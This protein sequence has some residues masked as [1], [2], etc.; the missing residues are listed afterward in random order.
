[1]SIEVTQ[2]LNK[3]E[4]ILLEYF[5]RQII[6][7]EKIPKE[8]PNL[9][10]WSTIIKL[11]A[12]YKCQICKIRFG[13]DSHHIHSI[14]KHNNEKLIIK[15]GIYLCSLCHGIAHTNKIQNMMI[16]SIE[17][18]KIILIN[19]T[20]EILVTQIKYIQEKEEKVLKLTNLR[21]TYYSNKDKYKIKD[22]QLPIKFAYTTMSSKQRTSC[23]CSHCGQKL[24]IIKDKYI[25]G[26]KECEIYYHMDLPF[27]LIALE[28]TD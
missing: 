21:S 9:I 1:M 19:N 18:D 15:N 20:R 26:N 12:K 25:C 16:H 27:N 7:P 5:N 17:D 22:L 6:L 4:D 2:N 10:Y 11:L 13:S 23:N 28:F 3:T 8:A 14:K 24:I